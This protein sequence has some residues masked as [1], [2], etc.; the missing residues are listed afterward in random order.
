MKEKSTDMN[1][2]MRHLSKNT[3][4]QEFVILLLHHSIFEKQL[5]HPSLRDNCINIFNLIAIMN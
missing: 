3:I 1:M 4:H 2:G 5:T